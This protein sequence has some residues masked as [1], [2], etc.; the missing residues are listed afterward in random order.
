VDR[1]WRVDE[2]QAQAPAQLGG[3]GDAVVHAPVGEEL[4]NSAALEVR[5]LRRLV[6]VVA[7]HGED[8][9]GVPALLGLGAG[10]R[11]LSLDSSGVEEIPEQNECVD[12]AAAIFGRHAAGHRALSFA[13]P[14]QCVSL[15]GVAH[16]AATADGAIPRE[17]TSA[18]ASAAEARSVARLRCCFRLRSTAALP[19]QSVSARADRYRAAPELR[20][21]PDVSW[22]LGYTRE[23][24]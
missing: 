19:A 5:A 11:D 16:G 2:H 7:R 1:C 3:G 22:G 12:G 8:G 21:I 24:P 18:R 15:S 14:G 20:H 23:P 13:Q 17:T 9:H 10:A 6:V 4:G